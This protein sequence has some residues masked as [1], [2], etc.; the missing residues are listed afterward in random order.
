MFKLT[1]KKNKY[2]WIGIGF[3]GVLTKAQDFTNWQI[4]GTREI[5]SG[6]ALATQIHNSENYKLKIFHYVENEVDLA[7]IKDFL[8]Q[9]Y[10]SDVEVT[11]ELNNEC[12]YLLLPNAFRL[13]NNKGEMC[14]ECK[15]DFDVL[16]SNNFTISADEEFKANKFFF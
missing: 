14:K 16:T 4:K 2:Q 5:E 6:L 15:K 12:A 3:F 9:F 13:L 1:T 8:N 11:N 10:L 7:R